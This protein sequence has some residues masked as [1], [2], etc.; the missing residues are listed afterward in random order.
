MPYTV[1]VLD[2]EDWQPVA[3][4]VNK[5]LAFQHVNELVGQGYDTDVSI[6]IIDADAKPGY[7]EVD[8]DTLRME[9]C[10]EAMYSGWDT[11]Q[12]DQ[13]PPRLTNPK[14]VNP[15]KQEAM[16]LFKHMEDS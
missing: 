15:I 11:R 3:S 5:V 7:D 14:V 2:S 6:R 10:R 13:I 1:S 8:W 9:L 12:L 16:S 4:M